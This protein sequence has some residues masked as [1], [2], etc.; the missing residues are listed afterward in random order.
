MNDSRILVFGGTFDPI[1]LGHLQTLDAARHELQID[2][3]MLIPAA[4]SPHKRDTRQASA[5]DRLNMARLAVRELE[6]YT[7]SDIE[8]MRAPPSYTVDTL[9]AITGKYPRTDVVLLM[10]ADQ[11][12]KLHLWYK[13]EDILNDAIIAILQRPGFSADLSLIEM[14]LGPRL[15]Q[16]VHVLNTPLK[17]ISA[18][19]I[20]RRIRER[21]PID[22]LVPACVAAYIREHQLYQNIEDSSENFGVS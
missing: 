8:I 7:V 3:V 4:Q 20:R 19:E 2:R 16:R 21:E 9:R 10:G 15:A 11:L 13:I 18:T 14:S 1:H 22:H 5:Q 6:G 12:S 17:D